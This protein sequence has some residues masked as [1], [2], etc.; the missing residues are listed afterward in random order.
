MIIGLTGKKHSG[1]TTAAH[2]ICG[3]KPYGNLLFCPVSFAFTLKF[4][5]TILL[6]E[7]GYPGNETEDYHAN[8]SKVIDSLGVDTRYLMQT[9][10]SEW[11]R[12]LIHPDIWLKTSESM[13]SRIRVPNQVFD[14][15]RFENEAEFI[16]QRGGLIIHIERP[17]LTS[18]DPHESENGIAFKPGDEKLVNDNL[19]D[20][21]HQFRCLVE[22][23]LNVH[24]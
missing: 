11:G 15:V 20:F 5:I 13:L 1:K 14:D 3:E 6:N 7:L 16:R 19:D 23:R 9:L 8:K 24:A 21:L 4:M 2:S 10:G 22:N 17:G 18:E 12:T